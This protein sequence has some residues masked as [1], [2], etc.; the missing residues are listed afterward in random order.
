MTCFTSRFAK[1][2]DS[3]AACA[4]LTPYE[5]LQ[6]TSSRA[7]QEQSVRKCWQG[8]RTWELCQSSCCLC[9]SVGAARLIPSPAMC[10][11]ERSLREA[12]KLHLACR[13]FAATYLW[14]TG[15]VNAI[16]WMSF[17]CSMS[18]NPICHHRDVY[19]CQYLC[20]IP[21]EHEMSVMIC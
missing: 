16:C 15:Y 4:R 11:E 3:H 5:Q 8:R 2:A 1:C 9:C 13:L 7:S 19:I 14:L 6:P 10:N 21:A 18:S 12:S 20:V 17:G